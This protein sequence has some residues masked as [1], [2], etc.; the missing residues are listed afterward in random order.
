[1]CPIKQGSGEENDGKINFKSAIFTSLE[2]QK[3]TQ[4]IFLS[5]VKLSLHPWLLNA[6]S[7]AHTKNDPRR[8]LQDLKKLENTALLQTKR[9]E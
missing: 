7:C 9:E 6:D 4:N 5:C 3:I 8:N 1:M 2:R